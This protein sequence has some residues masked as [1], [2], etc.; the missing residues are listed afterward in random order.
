MAKSKTPE[1]EPPKLAAVEP[2]ATSESEVTAATAEGAGEPP[3]PRPFRVKFVESH[4]SERVVTAT[5]EA[6][7]I[8]SYKSELG[9]WG[10]PSHPQVID[11]SLAP[12]PE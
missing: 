8:E 1:V 6:E 12:L 9:I 3:K 5:S 11:E 7:A 10:L 2:T 4:L